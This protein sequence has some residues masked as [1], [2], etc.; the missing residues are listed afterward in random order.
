MHETFELMLRTAEIEGS[1]S[2]QWPHAALQRLPAEA[3]AA[4]KQQG[5]LA[6][7]EPAAGLSCAEC[8][9]ACW[10]EPPTV[11][12]ASSGRQRLYHRCAKLGPI[13]FEADELCGWEFRVDRLAEAVAAAVRATGKLV[14]LAPGRLYLLGTAKVDGKTREVF[15]G[16]GTA[17]PDAVEVFGQAPRLRASAEPVVLTLACVSVGDLLPGRALPLRPLIEVLG[18]SEAGLSVCLD[19]AFP[20]VRPATSA[21]IPNEPIALDAFMARYCEKRSGQLRRFRRHAL[22][23]AARNG[24]VTLPPVAGPHRSGQAKKH[25]THDLLAAWQGFLDERVDLPPLLPQYQQDCRTD[26][27]RHL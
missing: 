17:W 4:L 24:K 12:E 23:G 18:A 13:W 25:F 11:T 14:Q 16:R 15:L 22:L 8:E 10:V 1:D 7:A 2:L 21:G 20:D 19:G 5:F 27:E 6:E 9:E 26:S 3:V